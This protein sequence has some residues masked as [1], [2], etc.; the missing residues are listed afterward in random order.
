MIKNG[1]FTDNMD[2]FTDLRFMWI[3]I[4]LNIAEEL[5]E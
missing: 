1:P 4:V 5:I 3:C 2:R